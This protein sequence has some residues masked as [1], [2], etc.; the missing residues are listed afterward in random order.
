MTLSSH[1]IRCSTPP[2]PTTGIFADL[3]AAEERLGHDLV[4][5]HRLCGDGAELVPGG[6]PSAG[7]RRLA[8]GEGLEF[9]CH[10]LSFIALDE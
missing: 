4:G 9:V 10:H 2:T 7:E 6:Q 3:P 8:V 1:G 5:A